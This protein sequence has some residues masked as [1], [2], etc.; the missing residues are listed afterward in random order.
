M[1]RSSM[2]N[3]F[4][5]D[6][7]LNEEQMDRMLDTIGYMETKNQNIQQDNG[8]PG[9][10]YFQIEDH[11]GSNTIETLV[12]QYTNVTGETPSWLGSYNDIKE[13]N[14]SQQQD[15]V[16]AGIYQSEGSDNRLANYAEGEEDAED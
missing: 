1:S 7:G 2:Y 8:G 9:Q 12:N 13:L 4:M 6:K 11:T 16:L 15:L 5:V 14:L 3:K 10:G